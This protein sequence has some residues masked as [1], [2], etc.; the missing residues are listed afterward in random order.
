MPDKLPLSANFNLQG[1]AVTT[2]AGATGAKSEFALFL[3]DGE[4]RIIR[5]KKILNR[6]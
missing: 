6:R 4:K 2:A 3:F 5:R 1:P